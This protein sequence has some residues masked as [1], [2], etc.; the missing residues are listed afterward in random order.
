MTR[1]A[2]E[3]VMTAVTTP[4]WV[5]SGQKM[6]RGKEGAD[7]RGRDARAAR[8]S[9]GAGRSSARCGALALRAWQA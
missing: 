6:H 4:P 5:Q 2:G 7:A 8:Q 1:G 3:H 9:G